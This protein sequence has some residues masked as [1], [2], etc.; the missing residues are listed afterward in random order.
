MKKAIAFFVSI[1]LLVVFVGCDNTPPHEDEHVWDD[2]VVTKEATCSELGEKTY[3]CSHCGAKKVDKIERN[4]QNHT[5]FYEESFF[6]PV[7]VERCEGC[8]LET[9]NTK[10]SSTRSL[11]GYWMSNQFDYTDDGEPVKMNVNIFVNGYECILEM[12]YEDIITNTHEGPFRVE[13]R[14]TLEGEEYPVVIA[15]VGYSGNSTWSYRI[16]GE[17]SESFTVLLPIYDEDEGFEIGSQEIVFKR[18]VKSNHVHT[19]DND[20]RPDEDEEFAPEYHYKSTNCS[21]HPVLTF[22]EYHEFVAG[23]CSECGYGEPYSVQLVVAYEGHV[24]TSHRNATEKDGLLLPSFEEYPG[25]FDAWKDEKGNIYEPGVKFYPSRDCVLV[26]VLRKNEVCDHNW[27]EEMSNPAT[28]TEQGYVLSKCSKCRERK[29]EALPVDPANHE[30]I[31]FDYLKAPKFFTSVYVQ[32]WCLNCGM[33][34]NE[35]ERKEDPCGYWEA[36]VGSKK[37]YISLDSYSG[38][39]EVEMIVDGVRTSYFGGDYAVVEGNGASSVELEADVFDSDDP[40]VLQIVSDDGKKTVVARCASFA[41]GADLTFTRIT[42]DSHEHS[43]NYVDNG[44]GLTHTGTTTCL[45]HDPFEFEEL[46]YFHDSQCVYC[47]CS[48]QQCSHEWDYGNVTRPIIEC[49]PGEVTYICKDCNERWVEL[50]ESP[51][52]HTS[53]SES[54]ERCKTRASNMAELYV[55]VQGPISNFLHSVAC[56]LRNYH[57]FSD[58]SMLNFETISSENY[59]SFDKFIALLGEQNPDFDGFKI[60]KVSGKILNDIEWVSDSTDEVA[61]GRFYCE[62]FKIEFEATGADSSSGLSKVF[63]GCYYGFD[64]ELVFDSEFISGLLFPDSIEYSSGES[65]RFS[66]PDIGMENDVYSSDYPF[67]CRF[68]DYGNSCYL[69]LDGVPVRICLFDMYWEEYAKDPKW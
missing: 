62:D 9:G 66:R 13:T 18:V 68:W 28:C 26:A 7:A 48:A 69:T 67:F 19:F 27:V 51:N 49:E 64:G 59:P 16:A 30:N 33:V 17:G 20:C 63:S 1:L 50:L 56:D 54:C 43:E 39:L 31:V 58:G 44:D 10:S 22:A 41:N 2:G 29:T 57:D 65:F 40:M 45:V 42:K 52:A 55:W 46:H 53:D 24:N 4:P 21:E 34:L 12:Q 35:V 47:E 23:K 36:E 15:D 8:G 38:Y 3:N 14:T 60:T 11:D 25:M 32:E 61:G 6:N 5:F 37:Y